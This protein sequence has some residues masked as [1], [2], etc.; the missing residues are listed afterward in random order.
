VLGNAKTQL[1]QFPTNTFGTPQPIL[2]C[3]LLDEGDGFRSEFR[4]TTVVKRFEFP[5]QSET[6][7]MPTEESIGFED[8]QGI[9]PILDATGEEDKPEAI[10]F[11][12][13]ELGDE[14]L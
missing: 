13:D 9:L 4:T 1:E 10:R 11:R 5:E 6:L 3:H 12:K 8:E 7:A 14:G 2:P